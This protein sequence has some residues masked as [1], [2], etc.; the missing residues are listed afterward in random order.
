MASKFDMSDLGKLSSY[1]G[2]EVKQFDGGITLNQTRYAE[3]ILEESGMKDCN[4][5]HTHRSG[6]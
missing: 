3:R 1:L 6:S 2:I 5:T 4:M